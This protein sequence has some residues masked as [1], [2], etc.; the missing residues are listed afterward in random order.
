MS[1]SRMPDHYIVE[2]VYATDFLECACGEVMRAAH[3]TDWIAHRRA[4]GLAVKTLSWG[5]GRMAGAKQRPLK[6]VPGR[7]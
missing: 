1:H 5:A 4:M 6:V 3:G 7:A 2:V